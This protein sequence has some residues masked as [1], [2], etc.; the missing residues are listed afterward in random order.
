[1]RISRGDRVLYKFPDPKS[2][3][4]D[5]AGVIEFIGRE[6]IIVKGDN[7]VKIKISFIN[8]DRIQKIFSDQVIAV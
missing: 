1:M 6:T 3:M 4:K 5:I 8:F 2:N 7:G